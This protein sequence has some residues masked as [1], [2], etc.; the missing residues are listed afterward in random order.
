MA[1]RPTIAK[2]FTE[3]HLAIDVNELNPEFFRDLGADVARYDS[4]QRVLDISLSLLGLLILSPL[5]IAL[6][7]LVRLDSKGPAF[8]CQIRVGRNARRFSILKFRTMIVDADSM[9]KDLLHLN[10]MSGPFFKAKNDPRV[11]RLGRFLRSWSLDELPQLINVLKGEMSIVGPRPM[12][13][14]EVSKMG[15]IDILAVRP[16]LTGFWQVNGRS[17][18]VDCHEK[19]EMDRIAIRKRGLWFDLKTILMTFSAV[20]RRRGAM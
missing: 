9:K 12:L 13:P 14:E 20:L 18:V 2:A 4:V 16:G 19:L 15:C 6:I 8:Y 3:N 1:V 11:T 5:F 10:I 17:D 7:I